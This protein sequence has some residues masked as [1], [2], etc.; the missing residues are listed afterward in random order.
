[1]KIP[2]YTLIVLVFFACLLPVMAQDGPG[3]VEYVSATGRFKI[4]FP[5]VPEESENTYEMKPGQ[6]VTH[7]VKLATDVTHAVNYTDYPTN[8]ENPE[9]VK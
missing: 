6:I 5:D 9:V 8:M 7:F 4:R 2:K 1:M 3:G